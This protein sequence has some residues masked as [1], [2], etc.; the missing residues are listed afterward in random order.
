LAARDRSAHVLADIALKLTITCQLQNILRETP[1][2][3]DGRR[4]DLLLILSIVVAL[5]VQDSAHVRPHDF[6]S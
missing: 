6:M 4:Q 2:N 5:A 1:R 3:L